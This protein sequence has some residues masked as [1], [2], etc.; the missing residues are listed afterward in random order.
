MRAFLRMLFVIPVGFMAA[1]AVAIGVY[2]AAFGFGRA[3]LVAGDVP[4]IVAPVLV[5]LGEIARF[6][7]LPFLVAIAAS[8]IFR[9]RSMIAWTLFGGGLGL[10]LHLFGFPGNYALLPPLAAGFA[11]GFTYWLIAGQGAGSEAAPASPAP[12]TS[13][14]PG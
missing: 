3:D 6:A 10:A 7:M 11:G 14:E 5:L 1:I 4:V 2:L 8:E 9:W 12:T 13:R